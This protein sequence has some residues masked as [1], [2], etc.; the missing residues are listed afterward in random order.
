MK[1]AILVDGGYYRKIALNAF[2][3]KSPKYT[4]DELISYC[5]R[6]LKEK[7]CGHDIYYDLYRIFYYDCP[8][9]ENSVYHPLT[10]K[11]INMKKHPHYEWMNQFLKELT[12]KRKLAL[13]LGKLSDTEIN[14]TLKYEA[15]KKLIN[16]TI[17]VDELT[18]EDFY[19]TSKQKGVDMKIGVDIASLSYKRQV[20][21]IILIAGDSDFVPASKLARREG[22]D[23]VLDSLGRNIK[24]DLFEH[25][26]GLRFCDD[27]LKDVNKKDNPGHIGNA[28]H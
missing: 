22:I 20:D 13:R 26:D 8:P 9:L 4:A 19:L 5:M 6:H 15:V 11:V 14:Y 21:K 28:K 10:K 18:N 3:Q 25:I 12:K 16:K 27:R 2:G 23:F 7:R 17:S 24:D 1:A